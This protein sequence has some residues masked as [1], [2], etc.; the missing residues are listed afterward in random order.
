MN[1]ELPHGHYLNRPK[2][3]LF[4]STHALLYGRLVASIEDLLCQTCTPKSYK[5]LKHTTHPPPQPTQPNPPPS[6]P[7]PFVVVE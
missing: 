1:L 3:I 5:T 4:E 2:T 6:P 7:P